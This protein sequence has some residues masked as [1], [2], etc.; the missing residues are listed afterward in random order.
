MTPPTPRYLPESEFQ[1][2]VEQQR[3]HVAEHFDDVYM[4]CPLC[5]GEWEELTNG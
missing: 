4:D 5:V 1:A 2:F 3:E